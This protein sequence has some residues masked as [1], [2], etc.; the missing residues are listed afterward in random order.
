MSKKLI[1]CR[2]KAPSW[3]LCMRKSVDPLIMIFNYNSMS[4]SCNATHTDYIFSKVEALVNS[5]L[6]S[7]GLSVAQWNDGEGIRRVLRGGVQGSR[8]LCSSCP[9]CPSQSYFCASRCPGCRRRQEAETDCLPIQSNS[10]FSNNIPH[11]LSAT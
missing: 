9:A 7:R 11:L 10:L 4:N 8:R 3:Q 6:V 2:G 5:I 1:L